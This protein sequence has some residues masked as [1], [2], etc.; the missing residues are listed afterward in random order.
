[1]GIAGLINDRTRELITKFPGLGDIPVLGQ[2]FTSQEFKRA[3]T[4]LMIFVTPQLAKPVNPDKIR[5]PTDDFVEPSDTEF[6]WMG[7]PEGRQDAPQRPRNQRDN[8][9]G[10]RGHFGQKIQN[11]R[12]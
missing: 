8:M 5:L 9:G 7:R 2:L 3:E 1:M 4:E 11:M 6:Y 10:L 12:Q